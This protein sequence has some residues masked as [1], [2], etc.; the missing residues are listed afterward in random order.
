MNGADGLGLSLA[1]YTAGALACVVTQRWRRVSVALGHLGTLAGAVAGAAVALKVL[2]GPPAPALSASLPPAFPFVHMSLAVDGLSAFFLLVISLVAAAAAIY[3]PAYLGTHTLTEG[4]AVR[5]TVQ[6]VALNVFVASMV[7]VVTAGDAF[8]FLFFWEGMTLASYALVVSETENAESTHA[9]L[10][11]VVMAHAGTAFL[12]V[13]FLVLVEHAQAFDFAALRAAGHALDPTTRTVLFFLSLAGFSAKAG[14]VPLH[15]WLPKAHPAAPSHVSA[16]MSGV[17]L[18]VAIYGMVR[19]GLDLLAPAAGPAATVLGLDGPR[20]GHA[21]RRA[22][23]ALRAPAARPQAAA[24]L[25]QRRERGDHPDGPGPGDAP[26]PR[27]RA[28]PRPWP[29]SRWRGPS[30]TP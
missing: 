14:V 4:T 8:T 9:G 10:L 23:R 6:T 19:F 30:C 24:G 3:A 29:R 7:L 25:P 16:L 27:R 13:V 1:C 22:R 20:P 28:W 21:L 2:L 17:M 5:A 18:K 15:V 26:R 11:Y 12:L